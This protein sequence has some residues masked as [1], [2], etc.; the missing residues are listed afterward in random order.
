MSYSTN[1]NI[2]MSL[3]LAY[4]FP[5]A[6][7]EKKPKVL[8]RYF[9]AMKK[10]SNINAQ[11][12]LV[13]TK[14][15]DWT[16]SVFDYY[17][18]RA[19]KEIDQVLTQAPWLLERIQKSSV[20]IVGGSGRHAFA[21]I[22]AGFR[23]VKYIDI[24]PANIAR[25]RLRAEQQKIANL[26][27]VHGDIMYHDSDLECFDLVI[28]NGVL[29]HLQDPISGL[30]L[31]C[32]LA[33]ENGIIYFDCYSAGS[34]YMLLLEWLRTFYRFED[35]DNTIKLIDDL[36]LD[37]IDLNFT[38]ATFSQRV[39][40][41]LFVPYINYYVEDEIAQGLL[42]GKFRI[43][44]RDF[45]PKIDHC[46]PRYD[47]CQFLIQREKGST[48]SL[49]TFTATSNFSL[50]YSNFPYI[51]NTLKVLRNSTNKI[52]LDAE[53]RDRLLVGLILRYH[54]WTDRQSNGYTCHDELQAYLATL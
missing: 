48:S 22:N 11:T 40:D 6:T 18:D 21:A 47:S 9:L 1:L 3:Y 35:F 7:T 4:G 13:Y 46:L 31:I 43:L 14:A 26:S 44:K 25:A 19:E 8:V 23:A 54:D 16:D 32:D 42:Q 28:M 2:G 41:D 20:C 17:I 30:R 12:E 39:C 52:S 10:K 45:T 33:R 49:I 50:N 27:I 29:Q 38:S 5:N 37:L 53:K 36:G 34:L 51:S 24:T 15:L